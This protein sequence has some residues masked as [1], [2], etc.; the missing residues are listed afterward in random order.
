M[1]VEVRWRHWIWKDTCKGQSSCNAVVELHAFTKVLSLNS[2]IQGLQEKT[3]AAL[4]EV[5]SVTDQIAIKIHDVYVLKSLG[6]PALD[7][8]RNVVIEYFIGKG[9]NTKVKKQ[10][11]KVAAQYRLQRDVSDADYGQVMK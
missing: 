7:Q 3:N 10:E 6:K 4:P 2:I 1:V 11:I 9:R 8:F 5:E